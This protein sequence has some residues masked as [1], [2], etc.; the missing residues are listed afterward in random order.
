M[1]KNLVLIGMPSA[2][3]STIGKLLTSKTGYS[4]MDTDMVIKEQQKRELREIVQTD[5]LE[6]FLEIQEKAILGLEPEGQIIATGGSVVYSNAAME[7]LK[8]KG[9]VI[10]L[11]LSYNAIQERVVPGRRFA[12]KEEQSLQD[13]YNERIPLYERYADLIVDCSN[14]TEEETAV[15][16][17]EE[18]MKFKGE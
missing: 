17:Y 16:V 14:M 11:K 5:G 15:K 7:H 6:Y 9:W 8:A 18:I 12:R 3:K 2:G 4:F 13:L 1:E 10:Y